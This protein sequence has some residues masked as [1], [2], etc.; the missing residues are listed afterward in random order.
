M[1]TG[2]FT[3][4]LVN[5][6]WMAAC[7]RDCRRFQA[8][9][10]RVGPAQA[11]YLLDLLKRNAGT[12]VGLK[13]GFGRLRSVAEYQD[14]VP[15]TPYEGL[16]ES[17]EAIARGDSGV[18][19]AERGKLFQPTSGS[20]AATKL[21]PWTAPLGEEFRRGIAPW[22]FA[23]YRRKPALLKGTAYWS[24]SPPGT[25]PQSY[26]KLTVGFN[27][28]AEYLGF[29]GRKLFS[30]VSSTPPSA[31]KEAD[32]TEF[33]T[34]TLISLLADRNLSLISI[35][36]PTFL[37]ILLDDFLARPEAILDALGSCGIAGAEKR[38]E[39]L[40]S[41]LREE[42]GERFFGK[43]WPSLQ[44]ISCWTHGP[45]E[46]CADALRRYFPGIEIQGKGLVATEAFVSLPFREGKDPVLAVTSH[47]F[48]FEEPA[49]GRI[50]L[51]NE[52]VA[53]HTYRVIVTTGGGLYR[54]PLGDL[55]EVTG[56]IQEAPCLR[57]IGRE[58]NISDLFGEKLHG[59]FVE[60]VVR[61]VLARQSLVP[62]FFLL[63]PAANGTAAPGYT[64]FLQSEPIPDP[65]ALERD[66]ELGLAESFHYAHCRRLGQL[67]RARLFMI[68][69]NPRSAEQI[70]QQE[71]L[72]RG[73]KFGDI[74]LVPL[75]RQLGWEHRFKGGFVP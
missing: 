61:R 59:V 56:F 38:A 28:D 26:G 8:A 35:W 64:L 68:R 34:R 29:L 52:V 60:A 45:S 6:A 20:S 53:G 70:F 13:L 62:G 15:I 25:A 39:R 67:T 5:G 43:V 55:V 44:V 65:V 33:K 46:L 48:E 12:R 42:A 31:A 17:I 73:L 3:R 58:G 11:G 36:S 19:T 63:A 32:M 18:L 7:F 66:L 16:S 57:F 72:S 10:R 9:L 23:L 54:Y 22:I 1:S 2:A 71:M 51:A 47:F 69:G 75:D 30:L 40:R 14:R 49:N 24:V 4:S 41:M 74:K 37:T 50:S 21:I 27:H